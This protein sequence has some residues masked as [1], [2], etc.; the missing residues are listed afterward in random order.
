MS[1]SNFSL[2]DVS[3]ASNYITFDPTF[4]LV[5]GHR[6]TQENFEI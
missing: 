6:P 1:P 5:H 3:I 2:T 4:E